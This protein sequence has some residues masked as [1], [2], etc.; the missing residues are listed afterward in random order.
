MKKKELIDAIAY[1]EYTD[2]SQLYYE[3]CTNKYGWDKAKMM[4]LPNITLQQI[5]K[6]L[7]LLN[8]IKNAH[9]KLS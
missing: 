3:R 1:Y 4:V 9:I 6:E 2:C 5:Y 8:Q 7:R